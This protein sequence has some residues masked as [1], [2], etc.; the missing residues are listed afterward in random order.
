MAAAPLSLSYTAHS[1]IEDVKGQLK[2]SYKGLFFIESEILGSGSI[3]VCRGREFY[4][5]IGFLSMEQNYRHLPGIGSRGIPD[6]PSVVLIILTV[7][8]FVPLQVN[9]RCSNTMEI[10]NVG[11]FSHGKVLDQD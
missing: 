9:H 6:Q 7:R 10:Y 4:S 3:F 1:I 2:V 11:L 5:P 8:H